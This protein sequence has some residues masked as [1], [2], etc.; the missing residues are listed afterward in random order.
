M[1]VCGPGAAICAKLAHVVA[2]ATTVQRPT[3]KPLS[4]VVKIKLGA[5]SIQPR[6]TGGPE[7]ESAVRLVG[8]AGSVSVGGGVVPV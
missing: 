8:A 6:F 1:T 2:G 5:L 4:G 3:T 7:G